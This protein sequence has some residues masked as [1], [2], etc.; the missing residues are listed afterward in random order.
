MHMYV[1]LCVHTHTHTHNHTHADTIGDVKDANHATAGLE[2][3]ALENGLH[4]MVGHTGGSPSP[5]LLPLHICTGTALTP[6]TSA[7]GLG[8]PC[9][10]R[11]LAVVALRRMRSHVMLCRLA[12]RAA[13]RVSPA[14]IGAPYSGRSGVSWLRR[15]PRWA[16]NEAPAHASHTASACGGHDGC[17][18][19]T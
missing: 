19:S 2:P 15:M 16:R 18:R 1:C 8:S 6:A 9:P 17:R 11:L 7:P 5:R 3:C 14:S 10:Q 13:S 4:E 12:V